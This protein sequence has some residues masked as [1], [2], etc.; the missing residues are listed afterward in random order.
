MKKTRQI[1]MVQGPLLSKLILFSIPVVLSGVLQLLFNAADVIVV[2]RFTGKEALAAVGSTSSLINLLIN[3][4][5]GISVGANVLVGQYIGARDR[6]NCQKTVHTGILFALFGGLFVGVFG[7]LAAGT[8]LT[9]MATPVNVLPLSTTY[10]QIYFIGLPALLIYDFGAALLRAIG[11]TRRPLYFLVISGIVNVVLNLYF[12]I[13]WNMGVAGVALATIISEAISAILVLLCLSRQEG[14]IQLSRKHLHFSVDKGIRMVKLGVPAG[15]QGMLFSI[16]NVLIQSSVNGFGATVMA[17]NTASLNIEN[18]VYISMN[19]IYQT[20]LS[21]TSQNM[22]AGQ[23]KR[24]DK[25]LLECLGIVT[26][27]G[28]VFGVGAYIFGDFLLHIYSTDPQVI[29]IGLLRLSIICTPYFLC[30]IMDVLVGSLRGMGYSLMPMIVS[31]IGVCLFRVVWIFTIFQIHREL[32]VLYISYPI[33]WILTIMVD[34]FCY[35]IIR[36][37]ISR[38][39]GMKHATV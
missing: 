33:S 25:I 24:I 16:S 18:F 1:D 4:F 35:K 6:E 10:M 39:A 7:F 12:V 11:D 36:K 17:G 2:G 15:V 38:K 22:G 26:L 30:G 21:F 9:W 27:I 31:L 28:L 32:F 5:L 8:L 20:A 29:K 3:L 23:Y 37:R 13:V 34:V 14:M 19:G